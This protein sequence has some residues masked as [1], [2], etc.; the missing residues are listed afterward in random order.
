[1]SE[2][3]MVGLGA[4]IALVGIA[5]CASEQ[6]EFGAWVTLAGL[7]ATIWGVHRFGR[8]GPDGQPL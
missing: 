5:L 1:M 4:T 3:R 7:V 6:A 2:R 8:T